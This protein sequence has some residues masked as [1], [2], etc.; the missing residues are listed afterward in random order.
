MAYKNPEDQ[1]VAWNRWYQTNKHKKVAWQKRRRERMQAWWAEF[2]SSKRCERCPENHPAC[3]VFHHLNPAE[4]D[5]SLSDMVKLGWGQ[6][7]V[8]MEVAKCIVLCCN[9]HA[10]LHWIERNGV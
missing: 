6:R 3:L 5:I 7:K 1:R 8:L 10:K 9:C 2:K 4:K